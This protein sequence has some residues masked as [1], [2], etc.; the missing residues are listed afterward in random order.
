ML[1]L[2]ITAAFS[3]AGAAPAC[4]PYLDLTEAEIAGARL[5]HARDPRLFRR[6]NVREAS[7]FT[8]PEQ[9]IAAWL[10]ALE[11]ADP[12]RLDRARALVLRTLAERRFS[13]SFYAGQD[14]IARE[15]GRGSLDRAARAALA[16]RATGNQRASLATWLDYLAAP[17]SRYYAAWVKYWTLAAIAK[18]GPFNPAKRRFESR[19][20]GQAAMFPDLNREALQR[21]LISLTVASRSDFNF[22]RAYAADYAAVTGEVRPLDVTTGEWIVFKRGGDPEALVEALRGMNTGWCTAGIET[23]RAHLRDG[24]FHVY[25]SH[26]ASGRPRVPRLAIRH[27]DERIAEVRGVGAQQNIDAAMAATDVLA[28]RL[29]AA[30]PE[31][32]RY[33]RA[34]RDMRRLTSIERRLAEGVEPSAEDLLFLYEVDAPIF[35]F[36]YQKDPRLANILNERDPRRDLV[37]ALAGRYG[38]DEISISGTDA[39]RPGVKFHYGTLHLEDRPNH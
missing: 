8:Q 24:D 2:F 25:I 27:E 34:E 35:G 29:R 7:T 38:A 10:R 22:A 20:R 1:I 19:S 39:V 3:I 14:Q 36:G 11:S 26:D 28:E 18:L 17:D 37:K 31:G 16:H 23:A 33:L 12:V 9:R 6:F 30:G 32:E 21:T 13:E 4:G 15:Q 5:L